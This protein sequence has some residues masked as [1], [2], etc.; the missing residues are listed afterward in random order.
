[1]GG[2]EVVL[3]AFCLH[4]FASGQGQLLL[5]TKQGLTKRVVLSDLETKSF[6]KGFRI[7]KLSQGDE[8][9]SAN[10]ISPQTKYVGVVSK[11]GYGVRY[12]LEDVPLQGLNSKGVKASSKDD[13]IAGVVP[14]T[15]Q[16]QVLFLTQQDNY[17]R[18]GQDQLPLYVRP[19]K[20]I[21]L[22]TPLKS[23]EEL[24]SRV[25]NVNLDDELV[26]LNADDDIKILPIKQTK[27]SQIGTT[28]NRLPMKQI[29]DA[30]IVAHEV[31]DPHA[32]VLGSQEYL[33]GQTP[34]I[35]PATKT[36]KVKQTKKVTLQPKQK[37]DSQ[38]QEDIEKKV[39]S[40]GSSLLDDFDF[41]IKT[42]NGEEET[43]LNFNDLL[44]D[45]DNNE[46]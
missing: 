26:L 20:G 37:V 4:D 13:L 36:A 24:V 42:K 33:G 5:G 25:F 7:M 39:N 45:D 43:Q 6:N 29:V 18:L 17:Q 14:L 9:V 2:E 44:V 12:S 21:R 22:F 3:T 40:L 1:M 23:K 11:I 46:V 16:E 30:Y 34:S 8:V 38:L 28:A 15:E 27:V 10:L 41:E 19:K 32:K 31:I 35:P